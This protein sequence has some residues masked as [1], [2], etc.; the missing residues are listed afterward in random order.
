[1]INKTTFLTLCFLLVFAV[2]SKAQNTYKSVLAEGDVYKIRISQTG[3]HKLSYEQIR[4]NTQIPVDQISPNNIHLY[5]NRGGFLPLKNSDARPD[6]LIENAIFVSGDGDNSFDPGDFI[7][8]YA[9]GPDRINTTNSKLAFEKNIYDL[10]NYYFLKVDELIGKRIGEK[11]SVGT[12]EYIDYTTRLLRHEVDNNN[13]LGLYGS[14][15]GSGKEWYGEIFSNTRNQDFSSSFRMDPSADKT[16]GALEMYFTGRSEESSKVSITFNGQ[17]FER[18]IPRVSLDNFEGAYANSV[19]ISSTIDLSTDPSVEINF[20][21]ANDGKTEAWLD[22]IQVIGN[23]KIKISAIPFTIYNDND[24]NQSDGGY[25]IPYS[26]NSLSIWDITELGNV[27]EVNYINQG[28]SIE[29]GYNTDN[30]INT[31]LAFEASTNFMVPSFVGKVEN[32]NIHGLERVDL[33]IVTHPNFRESAEMLANHR[34]TNDNLIVEIIDIHQVYNEF[35][36]GKV[37]PTSIR[38]MVRMLHLRDDNFKYLV[39]M[40]DA[41]YD[42]RGLVPNLPNHNFVPTYETDQSLNHV[43]SYPTDDY[44]GLLSEDEGSDD[45]DGTLELGIGRIPAST[46]EQAEAVVKKIIHY[47]TNPNRFGEWRTKIGFAA[48]D[49]DANWDTTHLRDADE[50]ARSTEQKH[51]NLLQQKVYFDSYKQVAT[52]GG[53]RYPD[54]NKAI[55]DNV[56]KGQLVFNYLGHGGPKGLSQERVLQIP[57]IRSWSNMDKLSVFV[58][59]TCSFTGFDEPNIVSAGEHLIMN[60]NGGAVALFTTVRSVYASQNKVLTADVYRELFD[61]TNG[62]PAR[63]GDVIVSSKNN[64]NSPENENT[65]KFLLMG[66]PSMK[67][68]LPKHDI[69]ITHFNESRI[70]PNQRDTIGALGRATISGKVISHMDSTTLSNFNGEVFI[71]IYDK[72]SELQTLVNDGNGAPLSFKV[73]KNVL[74]KGTASVTNG[75]DTV[76]EDKEGPEISIFFNDRTFD[77]GGETSCEPV[78]IVDLADENGINLSSTSI[79][80]DITATLEDQNG[81]KIVLNDFYKP[82]VNQTGQ[83][84]VTYEMGTLEPGPHKIYLKAWDILNNSTEEVMEFVVTKSEDG[85]M[86]N[87]YNYPNPFSTHTEFTFEH[88]LANSQVDIGIGIY[89]ISGKLIKSIQDSRFASGSRISDIAWDGRDDYGNKLAKGI[90]LYKIKLSAPELNLSRESDFLKLVLIN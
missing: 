61:R 69:E 49:V 40:G 64:G 66:D 87:V 25:R 42:Y 56:F 58:T 72:A 20:Q 81:D 82:T 46:A 88:D 57:D 55:N 13:L 52:P 45:L 38:D 80:H 37:D 1:M 44:F 2:T 31:F 78:L 28:N 21:G 76:I 79:G 89:T 59:A 71:T 68:A 29:F 39:L 18:T 8:F 22:Y 63:L 7:L 19:R 85:Q 86:Q 54:A 26:G 50:I 3:L 5:G 24:L 90:Y 35:A 9:E 17:T 77:F 6:D 41:T 27:S 51:P 14:A 15:Q 16:T 11:N 23:E 65:R 67:L 47:D 4:D 53:S 12:S 43:N 73:K 30:R 33:I 32:Q 34:R 10:S 60:P 83:G 36:G 70:V 84:T 62:E 75:S 48:D 74:Y